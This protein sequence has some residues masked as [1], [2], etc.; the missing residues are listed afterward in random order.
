MV[1]S[2]HIPVWFHEV[3][4]FASA[5]LET[6]MCLSSWMPHTYSLI[7]EAQDTLASLRGSSSH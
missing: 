1:V 7:V 6:E 3:A 4:S 5:M 2:S